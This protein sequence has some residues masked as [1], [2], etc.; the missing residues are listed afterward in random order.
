V[1]DDRVVVC[2]FSAASNVTGIVSDVA[3]I[4]RRVKAAGAKIVWDYAGAG[5]YMPISM[6]PARGAEID[7][8]VISPHKFIGGPGASGILIVRKDAVVADK[9]T[10]P[11]GGT[12][13][14]VS[15]TCHDYSDN[16]EA[17]EESGTPNLLGDIR[18]GLVFLVKQAIGIETTASRNAELTAR[19]FEAWDGIET[20]E[21]L[22][23][24]HAPR[25]PIFSLRIKDGRGG[26]MHQQ[27]ITRMLS[28]CYGIQARG[29]CA[30]AGPYVHQLLEIDAAQSK[31]IREQIIA[32][33]EL[34]KPGFTRLNFSVLLSDEKVNIIIESVAQLSRDAPN[35]AG[36]Y[37]ADVGRAIF[38]PL[39]TLETTL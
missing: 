24:L 16:L 10:W 35:L 15:P 39:Q 13:R 29:G 37:T 22:G 20:I 23:S 36:N 6:Q 12:V 26:Y 21:I 30:C 9:P 2:A 17:R 38:S 1:T 11:G 14:F 34:L 19:V 4:T 32:G 8:I 25:L 33:N 18:A 3:G 27:L 7:A 28:D 31:A 5:P